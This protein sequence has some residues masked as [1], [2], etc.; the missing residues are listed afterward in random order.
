MARHTSNPLVNLM[1]AMDSNLPNTLGDD[2]FQIQDPI[3]GLFYSA[4]FRWKCSIAKRLYA[5]TLFLQSDVTNGYG[6]DKNR[7]VVSSLS[8]ARQELAYLR[9]ICEYWET[10][11]PDRPLRSLSRLELQLMVRS[12]MVKRENNESGDQILG[13][14]TLTMLCK[15]LERTYLFSHSGKLVDGVVHRMTMPFKKSTMAPLLGSEVDFAT[16]H[17]G[18]SYG[19]IPMTCA[20]LMLAEAITLIES[21]EA[22]IAVAFFTQW[23]EFKGNVQHWF[24]KRDKLA[25]F[26]RLNSPGYAPGGWEKIWAPSAEA[27]G[28]A[29]D[30]VTRSRFETL[31]WNSPG[32]LAEFCTELTTAALVVIALLSGFRLGEIGGMSIN[33]Y[34]QRPDGSWWFTS[35]NT[36]T[37]SGFAHPRSL[38]G[39]AAEAAN[40]M[41]KLTPVDTDQINLPLLH[42]SYTLEGY[43]IALGWLKGGTVEEWLVDVGYSV[44]TL[45]AWFKRFYK[46]KV[47]NKYPEAAKLL[48]DA[49]PHQARHTF[50]EFALRRFDGN[51]LEKIREHFRHAQGSSHTQAYARG[52]LSESV[53]QSMERDYAK[54]VIGRISAGRLEDRFYGPAAKRIEK[55]MAAISVL[56]GEEF[57]EYV[58][59]LAE[60]IVRFTAFEWGYCVLRF[61]E[62]HLAKCHDPK[63]G[64]PNVDQRSSP[65]VCIGCPHGMNNPLQGEELKRIGIAHQFI[66]TSHPLKTIGKMSE[67]VVSQIKRR[68]VGQD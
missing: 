16:W 12:L 39:L 40:L 36:K 20:S 26:R 43:Q 44:H 14:S 46:E 41:K 17:K 5:Q 50:A 15:L 21:D 35:E 4:N 59:T 3:T 19:S 54:E 11:F 28:T 9:D 6:D 29:V 60:S 18:G 27:L 65:G 8:S 45:R 63:T 24:G 62:Q 68:L 30:A 58:N 37:E 51:V 23:R 49:T 55:E 34:E 42:R 25:L 61:G 47:V 57:D 53:R 2:T 38:H 52:K 31:P 7:I 1:K 48:D 33:D 56:T 13:S 64:M 66:A 67:D 32:Q 22:A 10:H